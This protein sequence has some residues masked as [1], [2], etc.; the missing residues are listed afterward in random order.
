MSKIHREF[1]KISKTTKILHL[2]KSRDDFENLRRSLRNFDETM[3]VI[4]RVT[5]MR[6][7]ARVRI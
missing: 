5:R 2:K 4:L 7:R 6:T 3:H 1:G